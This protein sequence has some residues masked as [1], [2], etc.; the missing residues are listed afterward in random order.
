VR[1]GQTPSTAGV[2]ADT[3]SGA[4][5]AAG[6][7]PP[8]SFDELVGMLQV[9]LATLS[10]GHARVARQVLSDPEGCAFMTITELAT[11]VGVNESTVVRFASKLGLDG[12]PALTAL[13]R[14]RLREQ[15]Q[16]VGRFERLQQLADQDG[17]RPPESTRRGERLSAPLESLAASEQRNIVRT[18]A[19]VDRKDWRR[20]VQT[21]ARSRSVYVIGLRKCYAVAYLLSYLLGLIRDDVRHVA[22]ES[23][24]LADALRQV[25]PKDTFIAVSIHRYTRD[26]LRALRFAHGR[27]AF[28][29]A[30]TDNA[31]SPLAE[32]A[33]VSFYI[34]TSSSSV[35]RSV[36]AFVSLVQAFAAAVAVERGTKARSALLLEEDV[37]REFEVYEI[38]GSETPRNQE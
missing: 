32:H 20:A 7:Q 36:S 19:R 24:T 6:S 34:D 15:A 33:D 37:L 38:D 14:E 26:T 5:D 21:A 30:L 2:R 3:R 10:D 8:R 22:S 12:Y 1:A 27:G 4:R 11:A 28:T 35:L 23:G 31:A 25:G 13:C 18:F 16:L 17:R 29:I 9:G